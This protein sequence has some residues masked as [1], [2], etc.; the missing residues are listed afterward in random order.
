MLLSV[1]SGSGPPGALTEALRP[2]CVSATGSLDCEVSLHPLIVVFLTISKLPLVT[3]EP[4]YRGS[5]SDSQ[6]ICYSYP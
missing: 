6:P 4:K 2:S 5:Q 1:V 3:R